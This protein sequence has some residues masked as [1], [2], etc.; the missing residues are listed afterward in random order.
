M[1]FFDNQTME[2]ATVKIRLFAK[3]PVQE[4]NVRLDGIPLSSQG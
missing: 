4:W 3:N 1:V 2:S